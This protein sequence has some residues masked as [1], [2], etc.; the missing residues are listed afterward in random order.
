MKINHEISVKDIFQV[1]LEENV[2]SVSKLE[3]NLP[4]LIISVT[5]G[6]K[7]FQIPQ[8]IKNAFKLGLIKA[9]T[10][11]NT[12]IITGG[13]HTGVMKL[14]GEAV[15]ESIVDLSKV[16]VLGIATFGAIADREKL[17]VILVFSFLKPS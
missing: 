3:M 11:T 2:F 14:V 4:K 16:T 8:N 9:A 7:N 1:S 12:L 15:V 13:T 5:G 17:L 10:S 6:A